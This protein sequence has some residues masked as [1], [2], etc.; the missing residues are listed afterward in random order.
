[1]VPEQPAHPLLFGLTSGMPTAPLRER[2]ARSGTLSGAGNPGDSLPQVG[3][4]REFRRAPRWRRGSRD[5]PTLLSVSKAP[6]LEFRRLWNLFRSFFSPPG[7]RGTLS[8]R[9]A[10][11]PPLHVSVSS[12]GCLRNLG[13]ALQESP[14]GKFVLARNFNL[15]HANLT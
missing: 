8:R 13:P 6:L 10:K 9:K 14:L 12:P 4:T 3:T 1:M 7:C 11:T 5:A 15:K 2:G